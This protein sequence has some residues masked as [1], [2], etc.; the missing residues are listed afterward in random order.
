MDRESMVAEAK[1]FNESSESCGSIG[2]CEL[3]MSSFALSQTEPLESR[4]AELEAEKDKWRL[5]LEG[6]TPQGSE[7]HN[8]VVACVRHV[9]RVL[10]SKQKAIIE[11]VKEVRRLEVEV[12]RRDALIEAANN[13]RK[14]CIDPECMF[15]GEHLSH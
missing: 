10:D 15:D 14:L 11:K 12:A 9:R 5:A 6:L 3:C 13:K 4:I 2:R 7:F 8:D 1:A